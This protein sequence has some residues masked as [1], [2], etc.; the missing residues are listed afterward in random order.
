VSAGSRIIVGEADGTLRCRDRA[1]GASLWTFRTTEALLAPAL[2]DEKGEIFVGTTDRQL[3]RL[4]PKGN[5]RWRWKV[6]ADVT[7]PPAVSG[8]LVLFTSFDTTL[9]GIHRGSGKLAF[10]RGLPSR[11]LSGP[12]VVGR[13]VLVACHENEIVGFSLETFAVVG[14]LKLPGEI[15]TPPLFDAGRIFVGLRD[16]SVVALQ[17][18]GLEAE[19]QP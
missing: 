14:N 8:P 16:R 12:L 6:G 19:S 13:T 5:R 2:V 15:R 9:Y 17:I 1:T 3:L 10:R 4:G 18:A 7:T 11:P